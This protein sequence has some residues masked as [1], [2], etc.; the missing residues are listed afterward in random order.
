V[1]VSKLRSHAHYGLAVGMG[2]AVRV[3]VY[4]DADVPRS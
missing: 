2:E 3:T 1:L 4:H